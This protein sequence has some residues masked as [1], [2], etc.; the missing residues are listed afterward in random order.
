MA[1]FLE[2]PSSGKKNIEALLKTA[3]MF[4]KSV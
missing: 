3:K 4:V 1:S 2:T